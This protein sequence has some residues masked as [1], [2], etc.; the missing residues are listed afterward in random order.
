MSLLHDE[1]ACSRFS[2]LVLA[3]GRS[4][5]MGRDKAGLPF[6]GGTLLSHQLDKARVL[7]VDDVL[8]SGPG[9]VPDRFP[10]M[11]PLA[12]LYAGLSAAV[13]PHCIV[14]PVDAPLVPAEE[15]K[16]LARLHLAGGAAVT[17]AAH[18]GTAEPLIGIYD[19]SLAPLIA[20]C[21]Q[22]GET[23][24]CSFLASVSVRT[25]ESSLPEDCWINVNT[26]ADL[27]RISEL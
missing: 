1:P 8:V 3:G 19:S 23:K 7:G 5:R 27:G 17:L 14:V 18:G 9:G 26:P 24:V 25:A 4:S 12:G 16:R 21:L 10:G 2:F 6:R 15:L 11:G 20:V 13:H 22:R